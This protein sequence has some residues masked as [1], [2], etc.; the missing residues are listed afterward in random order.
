M[1]NTIE[2]ISVDQFDVEITRQEIPLW[3]ETPRRAINRW[4]K[5]DTVS[6]IEKVGPA[7]WK[8]VVQIGGD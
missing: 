1:V 5:F 3:D 2:V 6:S 8:T 4:F 7:L